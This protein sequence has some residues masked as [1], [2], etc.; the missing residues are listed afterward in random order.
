M[1]PSGTSAAPPMVAALLQLQ[2]HDTALLELETRAAALEARRA[3]LHA[4][5]VALEQQASQ[6]RAAAE[7]EQKRHRDIALRLAAARVELDRRVAVQDA[8]E[9]LA[10]VTAAVARVEEGRRAVS[11]L[12]HESATS[13]K[14]TTDLAHRAQQL[15][16]RSAAAGVAHASALAALDTEVA[17]LAESLGPARTMRAALAANVAADLLAP[18]DRVRRKRPQ[19]AVVPMRGPACSACDTAMPMQRHREMLA[20]TRIEVCEGCG[21]LLYASA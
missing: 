11:A 2:A 4:D 1:T 5:R 7:A 6:A 21:V 15:A 13:R 9:R 10:E 8:A 14:R 18:Y 19:E 12:E 20:A 3:T 16:A 17:A